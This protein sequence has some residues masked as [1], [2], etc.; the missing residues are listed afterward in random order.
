MLRNALAQVA[1]DELI[2]DPLFVATFFFTTG[3][4]ERQHLWRETLPNL[5]QQYW[6]TL[7]GAFLASALFTPVQLVSFRYL[8]VST[9]VLVVNACDVLWYAAVSIGRHAEGG[10][11]IAK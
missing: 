8:P 11:G 9:R 7:R 2:F 5:R 10:E 4:V 3:L 1:I 6:P